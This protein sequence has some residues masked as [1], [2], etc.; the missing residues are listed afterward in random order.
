MS[1][2]NASPALRSHEE[3]LRHLPVKPVDLLVMLSLASE[4][5]HGYG[6]VKAIQERTN[7]QVVLVP[8]NLYAMLRRLQQTELIV[9]C[10]ATAAPNA[11]DRRRYYRLTG[12]GHVVLQA[13]AERLRNLLSAADG[14]GL[15]DLGSAGGV[16]R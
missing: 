3:A 2:S 1:S 9:R 14:Q 4:E 11:D 12:L 13:E 15:I 10:D 8:T 6:L 7:G 5:L 16:S